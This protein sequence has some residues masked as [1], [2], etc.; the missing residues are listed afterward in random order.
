MVR[1]I[2]IEVGL[3]ASPSHTTPYIRVRMAEVR[4]VERGRSFMPAPWK[5]DPVAPQ[6]APLEGTEAGGFT[7]SLARKGRDLDIRP[8][9]RFK[10]AASKRPSNVRA[11]SGSLRLYL[12]VVC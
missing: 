1:A 3:A 12:L 6:A 4:W 10:V 5:V 2:V 7:L 9:G 11:F 8:Y